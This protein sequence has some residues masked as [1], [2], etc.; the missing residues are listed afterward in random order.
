M[1][2]PKTKDEKARGIPLHQRV[3]VALANLPHRDGEVF[4]RPDGIAL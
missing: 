3:V 1:T 2:F 4:R